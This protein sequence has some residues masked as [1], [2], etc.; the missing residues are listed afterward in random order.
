[1][2][3]QQELKR[4]TAFWLRD[5]VCRFLERAAGIKDPE[6]K[7]KLTRRAFELVQDAVALEPIEYQ[8]EPGS[9]SP[10]G[11]SKP[12]AHAA[13]PVPRRSSSRPVVS[14]AVM[15]PQPIGP[16]VPGAVPVLQTS[17]ANSFPKGSGPHVH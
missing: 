15:S 13:V 5:Q 7:R 11:A 9:L 8:A 10:S 17:G 14:R 16:T 1:M 12:A 4:Q 3:D 2:S 6:L